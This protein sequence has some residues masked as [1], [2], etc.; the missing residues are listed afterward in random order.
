MNAY[1]ELLLRAANMIDGIYWDIDSQAAAQTM[2]VRLREIASSPAGQTVLDELRTRIGQLETERM[3]LRIAELESDRETLMRIWRRMETERERLRET[4][5]RSQAA[6][7]EKHIAHRLTCAAPL[8]DMDD[9]MGDYM[10]ACEEE[11][12]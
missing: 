12:K 7:N 11:P 10:Y 6:F 2:V 1:K 8:S 5:A 9:A 3:R 4:L